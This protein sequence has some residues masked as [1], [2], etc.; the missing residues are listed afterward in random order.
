MSIS[1]L[2]SRFTDLYTCQNLKGERLS[3]PALVPTALR[4]DDE[5][6]ISR[7]VLC[8]G[9]W[10]SG[11]LFDASSV[12]LRACFVLLFR[13]LSKFF[14]RR[15]CR[16]NEDFNNEA[17]T[18]FRFC[19]RQPRDMVSP[20]WIKNFWTNLKGVHS[21]TLTDFRLKCVIIITSKSEFLW[22]L[23]YCGYGKW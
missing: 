11:A 7:V 8:Q 12:M 22:K 13:Y 9:G 16:E 15:F 1:I 2:L 17:F 23:C 14:P 19:A 6:Q 10:R 21:I 18:L 4:W 3:P 5:M 20:F